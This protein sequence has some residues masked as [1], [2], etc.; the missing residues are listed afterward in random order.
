MILDRRTG[1]TGSNPLTAA[2]SHRKINYAHLNLRFVILKDFAS[3]AGS[4][5]GSQKR[6]LSGYGNHPALSRQR[7]P[8]PLHFVQ[9]HAGGTDIPNPAVLSLRHSVI[10]HELSANYICGGCLESVERYHWPLKILDS[11]GPQSACSHCNEYAISFGKPLNSCSLNLSFPL[12]MKANGDV[13]LKDTKVQPILFLHR[14][15]QT[16][17]TF[18]FKSCVVFHFPLDLVAIFQFPSVSDITC[19]VPCTQPKRNSRSPRKVQLWTKQWQDTVFS[20]FFFS[21]SIELQVSLFVR[22]ELAGRLL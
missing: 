12:S 1:P 20:Q 21:V 19:S 16:R 18:I 7:S 6:S 14:D 8:P 15:T 11:N 3:H 13:T 4:H 9:P 10:I 2:V 5:A 22:S 17:S